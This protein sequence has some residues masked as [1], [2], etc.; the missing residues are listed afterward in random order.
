MKQ[1][2]TII[3]QKG[4]VGKSTTAHALGWAL[5][6]RG[7]KVLFVDLD[8]QGNLS[9]SLR[10]DGSGATSMDVLTGETPISSAIQHLAGADVL[11]AGLG[12]ALA[13]QNMTGVGT[14]YRLK[15][16]LDTVKAAYDY[17][18]IDTPP[19]LGI[20]TVNALT[21]STRAVIPAQAD[22]YSFQG[23]S[24]LYK[25]IMTV[26]KYCNPEITVSG[27]L[28][29]R[30]SPRAILS[31]DVADMLSK[32]AE[33]IN[34]KLFDA[35]IREAVSVKEAQANQL[36]LYEYSPKSNVAQDYE[37]FTEELLKGDA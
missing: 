9:F 29:T 6:R 18:I 1:I 14:E 35:T 19:A 20:L 10:S 31:R 32:T 34:T 13:E 21:A 8:S 4:G 3:N 15:E 12:L 37:A 7:Y 33:Q 27:I 26:K 11:P 2:Y 28:L 36:D 16:A 22:I 30:Y 24:Q 5:A 17:I 25:T 23:V